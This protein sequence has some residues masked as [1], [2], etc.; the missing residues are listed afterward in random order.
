MA[1]T[2]QQIFEISMAIADSL[3]GSGQ[4]TTGD[5][6][7][8]QYRTPG[9]I[10]ILQGEL[11][12]KGKLFNIVSYDYSESGT[13]LECDVP[14][15]FNEASKIVIF[16]DGCAYKSVKYYIEGKDVEEIDDDGNTT[17]VNVKK[18]YFKSPRTG[19]IKME[20]VPNPPYVTS[21]SDELSLSD[22]ICTSV[23]P[24]GLTAML[25]ID[26]NSTL[27]SYCQQK[28]E[29]NKDDSS[30]RLAPNVLEDIEDTY[31][32]TYEGYNY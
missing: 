19:T 17:I 24:Y 23:L 14:S 15:D 6:L 30:S 29:E 25:F 22:A 8:Y 21:L 12:M 16:D 27:A 5:N 1:K 18:I 4:A 7:E 3:N 26:E 10:N 28:F 32:D 31:K 13:W 9:I 20:Y 11:A 2:V